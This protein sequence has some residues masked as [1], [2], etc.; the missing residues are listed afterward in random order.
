MGLASVYELTDTPEHPKT[1]IVDDSGHHWLTA[2]L[3]QN[4]LYRM[5][6][7]RVVVTRALRLH[8]HTY[9]SYYT[10]IEVTHE[11]QRQKRQ[12]T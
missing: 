10:L 1:A 2:V 5:A 11:S 3:L 4:C 7:I 8:V 6:V 12:Q 9:T